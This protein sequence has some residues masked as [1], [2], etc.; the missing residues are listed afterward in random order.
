MYVS[1]DPRKNHRLKTDAN[2]VKARRAFIGIITIAAAD[3]VAS[4]NTAVHAAITLGVAGADVTTL[5]TSPATPRVIRI[6]GS[7]AGLL[8][9]VVITGTNFN[10]D[11]ITETIA[12]NEAAA[13]DG[14]KAFATVTKITVPAKTGVSGDTISVGFGPALGLPYK[15]A[16]NT[17]FRTYLNDTLEA[18]APTVTTSATVLENNT[19]TLNS[20]LNASQIDVYLMV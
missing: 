3:A 16:R 1:F 4:S 10:G 18:T 2:L 5:I 6:K 7:Q 20:T 9:N 19:I 15:L 14:V 8:G 12:A 13:V 17:V 11:A